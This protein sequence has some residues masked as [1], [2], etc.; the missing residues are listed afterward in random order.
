MSVFSH[1]ESLAAWEEMRP[2]IRARLWE[3]LGDLPPLIEPQVKVLATSPRQGC[4]LEKLVFENGA[5]ANV[6]GYLLLPDNLPAPAILYAHY[7]GGKHYLGKN[8]MLLDWGTDPALG[9][10]LA[11]LG[12][13]VLA[14]DAYGFGER[15]NQ[16]AEQGAAAEMT[17]FKQFLWEG[18]TLWGM[19]L[20]DDLLALNYLISRP[21]VDP[22]RIGLTGMS[23]GASR[24]TWL[25]AL[26]DRPKAVCPVAQMTRYHDFADSGH[27][28]G[29]GIYYY[30]PRALVS[31]VEMEHLAAL[32]APRPQLVL[33]G[34]QDPLSPLSGIQKVDRFTQLIYGLYQTDT[35]HTKIYNGVGH[36]YTPEMATAM[37]Q[38]FQEKL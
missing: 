22:E 7:H 36:V 5:G 10:R 15:Q 29:H 16:G 4:R 6:Y 26:D 27:Y 18:R 31:G 3:L 30:V 19:M 13:V 14:I 11:Q 12:F 38:F 8:E 32:A 21:E 25:A 23:L 28:A 17:L 20:R 33:I 34:D 1:P 9:I 24:S 35:F 37:L 2:Q